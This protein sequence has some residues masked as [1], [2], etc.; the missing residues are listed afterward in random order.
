VIIVVMLPM[1]EANIGRRRGAKRWNR[2]ESA[3]LVQL[4]RPSGGRYDPGEVFFALRRLMYSPCTR[5]Y[6]T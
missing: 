1:I 5:R 6:D 3:G 2:G 4:A